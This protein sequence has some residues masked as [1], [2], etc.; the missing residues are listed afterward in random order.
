MSRMGP[1]GASAFGA[2]GSRRCD[3][4][5][6]DFSKVNDGIAGNLRLEGVKRVMPSLSIKKWGRGPLSRSF[7]SLGCLFSPYRSSPIGKKNLV[8]RLGLLQVNLDKITIV[9]YGGTLITR[10]RLPTSLYASKGANGG[11]GASMD[12]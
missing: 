1:F 8:L 9:A 3:A 12:A 6:G 7:R 5:S 2:L 11:T 10:A 4:S